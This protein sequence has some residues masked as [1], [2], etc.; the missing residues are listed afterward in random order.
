MI[1]LI[2]AAASLGI[3][4]L[5]VVWGAWLLLTDDPGEGR[6]EAGV[7]LLSIGVAAGLIATFDLRRR[8]RRRASLGDPQSTG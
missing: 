5:F 6:H 1:G 2:A 3:S 8:W 4:I 7:I